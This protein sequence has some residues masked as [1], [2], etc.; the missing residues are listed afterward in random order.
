MKANGK[1]KYFKNTKGKLIREAWVCPRVFINGESDFTT[2]LVVFVET[3]P[4]GKTT[5][6]SWVTNLP[7]DSR[8]IFAIASAGRKRWCIENETF[9]TLKNQGYN[10]EHNYGHG[11]KHLTN[12]LAVLML[13]AFAIDQICQFSCAVFQHALKLIGTKRELWNAM[14]NTIRMILLDDWNQLWAILAGNAYLPAGAIPN[15]VP[16]TTYRK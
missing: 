6:F 14:R 1:A 4:K 15:L 11:K 7:L 13:I 2:T 5:T 12:T 9:N 3:D 16:Q 10:L 8:T